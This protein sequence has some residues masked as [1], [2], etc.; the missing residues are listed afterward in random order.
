MS[1]NDLDLPFEDVPDGPVSVGLDP[2]AVLVGGVVV[3]A[4][5]IPTPQGPLPAVI[6]DFHL[7]TG[8]ALPPVVFAGDADQVSKLVPLVEASAAAAIAAAGG[9]S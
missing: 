2:R 1:G 3:R 9:A 5:V 4:A 8:G 7:A 6:F